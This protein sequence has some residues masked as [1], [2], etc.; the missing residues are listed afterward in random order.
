V[1]PS[2]LL[3]PSYTACPITI[4]N[5]GSKNEKKKEWQTSLVLPHQVL[6]QL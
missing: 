1:K 5:K 4:K 6:S 3:L 2:S